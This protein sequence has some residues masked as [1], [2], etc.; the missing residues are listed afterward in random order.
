MVWVGE[1]GMTFVWECVACCIGAY[2]TSPSSPPALRSGAGS[3]MSSTITTRRGP[4]LLCLCQSVK[5]ANG[6][7][8]N[9]TIQIGVRVHSSCFA[10]SEAPDCS[11]PN[12]WNS[13]AVGSAPDQT[14]TFPEKSLVRLLA[15]VV[16]DWC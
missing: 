8:L 11:L 7:S 13:K 16:A 10:Y 4:A 5:I 3:T 2:P 6:F 9:F 12:A 15:V 14:A 1:D